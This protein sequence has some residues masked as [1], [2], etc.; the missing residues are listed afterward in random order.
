MNLREYDNC[1]AAELFVRLSPFNRA[2]YS[3]AEEVHV[4]GENRCAVLYMDITDRLPY[5]FVCV[6]VLLMLLLYKCTRDYRHQTATEQCALICLPHHK[7]KS[8]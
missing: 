3:L 2:V 4:C 8:S 5:I 1:D 7:A 6:C